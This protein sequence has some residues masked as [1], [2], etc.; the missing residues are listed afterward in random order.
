ML[1]RG[2]LRAQIP[3]GLVKNW[4]GSRRTNPLNGSAY[5]L[6]GAGYNLEKISFSTDVAI[7]GNYDVLFKDYGAGI[8]SNTNGYQGGGSTYSS[9]IVKTSFSS[10]LISKLSAT[11]I[12]G[13]QNL[14]S[15]NSR[16]K[17]YFGG[18]FSGSLSNEIDGII[19]SNETT[20]NPVATLVN[21][22]RGLV[23]FNSDIKGYFNAGL[24]STT[25]NTIDSIDFFSETVVR[26][27]ATLAQNRD[28][29]AGL[30]SKIK[31]YVGGG[32]T[33][34][35]PSN[36]IDGIKF[37]DE[38]AQNPTA[39]LS[40]LKS[41]LSGA[42]SEEKGYFGGGEELRVIDKYDFTTEVVL[43]LSNVFSYNKYGTSAFQSGGYL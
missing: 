41:Y 6:G 35:S 3:C 10:D 13:R 22:K 38:T 4:G 26:I 20:L 1:N 43:N 40:S 37:S 39:V 14:G 17:G 29:P 15:V 11:L 18:G 12:V 9:D 27:S 33:G 7:S 23:G 25:V 36:E 30:N 5:F 24:I 28:N 21:S 34:S 19:F 32:F 8:N 2:A 16:I 31:G 42:N